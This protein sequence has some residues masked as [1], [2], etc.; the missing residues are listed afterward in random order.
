MNRRVIQRILW[1]FSV[2]GAA[3]ICWMWLRPAARSP[4]VA[5]AAFGPAD[6]PAIFDPDAL[7]QAAADV[8][9]GDLFRP[10][11]TAPTASNAPASPPAPA[12]A[13]TPRPRFVLRGVIG[14]PPW[15]AIIDGLPGRPA[16][17]VVRN[18]ESIGGFSITVR[19]RDTVRVRGDDTVWTLTLGRA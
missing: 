9:E 6:Y 11:R 12:A 3:F 19:S 5:T 14:G 1:T 2:C 18:G 8:V 15:D 13:P 4:A 7:T 17:T 16:G 10:D